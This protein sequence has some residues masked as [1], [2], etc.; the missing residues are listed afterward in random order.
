MGLGL[1]ETM[2]NE[3]TPSWNVVVAGLWLVLTAIGA[4]SAGG[5]IAGRMRMPVLGADPGEREF[6]DGIH[7]LGVW[8]I[9][10]I[11]ALL[12]ST[13]VTMASSIGAASAS[14]GDVA[15]TVARFAHNGSVILAFG[16]AAAAAI[17]AGAA[18]FAAE[19]GGKHRDE[20]TSVNVVV[21]GFIRKSFPKG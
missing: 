16:T 18:W 9:G 21:P 15:E 10:S 20:N 8:A 11:L 2:V 4:S 17:G 1:G 6:R 3:T 14:A 13:I 7:G 12:A 19:A 5:Y